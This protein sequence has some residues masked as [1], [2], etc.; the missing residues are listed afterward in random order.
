MNAPWRL[1][2]IELYTCTGACFDRIDSYMLWN[3]E[4]TRQASGLRV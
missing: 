2:E 4:F 1:P 3:E